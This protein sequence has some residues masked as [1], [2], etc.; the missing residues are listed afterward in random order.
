MIGQE[1]TCE[2]L[3]YLKEPA[4]TLQ[5]FQIGRIVIAGQQ[6]NTGVLETEGWA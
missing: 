6:I 2:Q 3:I 1:V 4:G 5:S